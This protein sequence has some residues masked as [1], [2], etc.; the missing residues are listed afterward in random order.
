[1]PRFSRITQFAAV[2][3]D[4]ATQRN[5]LEE[6][7]LAN[8]SEEAI[9][10]ARLFETSFAAELIRVTC[11]AATKSLRER[12]ATSMVQRRQHLQYL[13]WRHSGGTKGGNQDE[14]NTSRLFHKKKSK[15]PR[16][17]ESPSQQTHAVD[18]DHLFF[19]ARDM[20]I[21]VTSTTGA[22]YPIR[23]TLPGY[24]DEATALSTTTL[25]STCNALSTQPPT[26]L[27]LEQLK[28][29]YPSWRSRSHQDAHTPQCP[30]CHQVINLPPGDAGVS[31]WRKHI[32]DDLEPFVCLL[33]ECATPTKRYRTP[34]DASLT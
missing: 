19:G 13:Q 20:S 29:E 8:R 27:D 22:M 4:H 26:V 15:T 23:R 31:S 5:L 17:S 11:P 18:A 10:S 2:V 1:M 7:Y 16:P 12:L 33:A 3:R 25:P 9:E 6:T 32:N 28:L 21:L 14:I 34:H 24:Y 30:Y